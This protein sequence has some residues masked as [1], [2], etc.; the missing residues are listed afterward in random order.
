MLL[1]LKRLWWRWFG[2]R[3]EPPSL[4]PAPNPAA[5]YTITGI[6]EAS[7]IENE[8]EKEFEKLVGKIDPMQEAVDQ[9]AADMNKQI[10]QLFGSVGVTMTQAGRTL[11]GAQRQIRRAQQRVSRVQRQYTSPIW[12]GSHANYWSSTTIKVQTRKDE[13]K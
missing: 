1:W 11:S 12:H 4:E 2:R 9:L 7:L 10:S 6:L 13:D 3:P 8:R 5:T